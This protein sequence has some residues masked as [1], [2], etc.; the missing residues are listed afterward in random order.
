MNI[1]GMTKQALGDFFSEHGENP[2]KADIVFDGFYRKN[3]RSF[4]DLGLSPRVT[5]LLDSS[6]ETTVPEV[7]KSSEAEDCSKLLLRLKDGETVETVLMRQKFGAWVCVSTEVG[8]SMGCSFCQSGRLKMRRRLAVDE[9]TGQLIAVM[10]DY[11]IRLSGISVMGI[12][13]PFDNFDYVVDFC[14]IASAA[15][16]LEIGEKHITVSTCGIVPRIYEYADLAH[17]CNLAISLHAPTDEL[18]DTL[19]PV[20]RA[21]PLEKLMSAAEY[22]SQKANRRVT[23]EYVM[24]CGVNDEPLHAQQLADL[25]AGR[26]FYVN[27]IPYNETDSQFTQSP[28]E[29]IMRFY[30]VLKKNGVGVTMRREFGSGVNGACGQLSSDYS[31]DKE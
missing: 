15:K 30:D 6:F 28:R 25:I 23:L 16:G 20:N 13:E 10:R 14:G 8:C 18:R 4:A 27:I 26:R 31:G 9:M 1:F 19:M 21:Y 7:I 12:G 29:R 24:L 2:A 5:E 22:F 11:N 3:A 17:P